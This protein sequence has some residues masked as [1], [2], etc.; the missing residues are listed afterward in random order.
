MTSI[1][2]GGTANEG[3]GHGSRSDRER[4]RVEPKKKEREQIERARDKEVH[5]AGPKG[6]RA[7]TIKR[8][9]VQIPNTLLSQ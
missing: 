7:R 9:M 5:A 8:Y 4:D 3:R 1:N 6:K 2:R